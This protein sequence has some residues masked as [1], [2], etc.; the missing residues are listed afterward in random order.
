MIIYI[1]FYGTRQKHSY[2]RR[3]LK[4]ERWLKGRQMSKHTFEVDNMKQK[5]IEHMY[6]IELGNLNKEAQPQFTPSL[7]LKQKIH[8]PHHKTCLK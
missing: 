2:T 5:H 4:A 7:T 3:I 6:Q 1:G 8:M